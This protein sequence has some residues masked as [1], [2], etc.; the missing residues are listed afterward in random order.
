MIAGTSGMP[1]DRGMNR[2]R[3]AVDWVGG[4]PYEVAMPEA[5]F[6]FLRARDFSLLNLTCG[7][8]G[9]GWN[10]FVFERTRA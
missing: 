10:E 2:W 3:D 5:V 4:H 7:G 6:E 8:V 1:A 9:L